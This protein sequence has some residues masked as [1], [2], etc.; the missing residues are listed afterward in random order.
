MNPH[1]PPNRKEEE[2]RK[3]AQNFSYTAAVKKTKKNIQEN[4]TPE[5]EDMFKQIF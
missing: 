5:M 1:W 3:A 2:L 4:C